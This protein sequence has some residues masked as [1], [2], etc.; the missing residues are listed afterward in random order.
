VHLCADVGGHHSNLALYSGGQQDQA[1]Y[2]STS[3]SVIAISG[4]PVKLG[5]NR[6]IAAA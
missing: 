5:A 2:I 6:D 1:F 4:G 3:T